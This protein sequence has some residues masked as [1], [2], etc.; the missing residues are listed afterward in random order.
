MLDFKPEELPDFQL[1]AESRN[2]RLDNRY[3]C[4]GSGRRSSGRLGN[5]TLPKPFDGSLVVGNFSTVPN[6]DWYIEMAVQDTRDSVLGFESQ[7]E[8]ERPY[9]PFGSAVGNVHV[10]GQFSFRA[11]LSKRPDNIAR[12]G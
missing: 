2:R 7:P 9:Q 5:W 8:P 6:L 10:L 3:H 12:E 4:T 1:G 11:V